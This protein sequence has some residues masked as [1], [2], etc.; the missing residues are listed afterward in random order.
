MDNE[1]LRVL[2]VE[3][4]PNLG[5]ILSE[6][7]DAKGYDATLRTDGDAGFTEFAKGDYDFCI[8]DVMMPKKDGFTLAKEIR[9]I[10]A[11]VPVI[12]LTAKSMKE[13]T[14]EGFRSGADDYI[15]KPFSME[16]LLM[17]M[18]AILRRTQEADGKSDKNVFEIGSFSYDYKAQTL[19]QNGEKQKLTSKENEL[20]RLLCIN[21]NRVL[22]RS[23]ALKAIWDD[24][25]YF[26]SR[27]MD[28]YIT[29]LRKYL[30]PDDK[31]EIV[32]VH[33]KGF[34]LTVS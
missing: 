23:Y 11:K 26:N 19:T 25:S 12:F 22:D 16:E 30:R 15:T 29:K 13:G 34:K 28:V 7:L 20:M 18:Q 5:T 31:V 8:L 10:N 24:D 32:N 3:D 14:L 9:K 17:R 2:V 1:K 27:S 6:Y 21:T 33:G 4:D